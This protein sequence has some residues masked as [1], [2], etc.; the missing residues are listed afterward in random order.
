MD[1]LRE[2]DWLMVHIWTFYQKYMV[3][4]NNIWLFTRKYDPYG[5]YMTFWKKNDPIFQ[6]SIC[7][8][9]NQMAIST[10]SRLP[11]LKI[12]KNHRKHKFTSLIKRLAGE[13]RYGLRLQTTSGDFWRW[14]RG[15]EFEKAPRPSALWPRPT[16]LHKATGCAWTA[17]LTGN[18]FVPSW[19]NHGNDAVNAAKANECIPDVYF[20]KGA[21][22][23]RVFPVCNKRIT[24]SYTEICQ[25]HVEKRKLVVL[26]S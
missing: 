21:L 12:S 26:K 17:E 23:S 2:M 6:D 24:N 8:E 14:S 13:N 1:F 20:V 9:K 11:K 5:P 22:H 18:V 3:R 7:W 10:I 4:T 25:I 15:N 19:Q 16:K